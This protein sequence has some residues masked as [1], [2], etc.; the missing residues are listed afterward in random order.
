[1]TIK[2]KLQ[3]I[4]TELKA[5]KNQ[6][7]DFGN[8]NYRS[9]ED[10]LEGV[11]PLL[12]KVKAALTISDEIVNIGSRY[13]IKATAAL[14]DLESNEVFEISAFAR[15]PE[16]RPKM[17]E[18]Q[19]TGSSSSYARKYALNGLFCIDDTRDPDA[20]NTGK[21]EEPKGNK[22]KQ[23]GSSTKGKEKDVLKE[24]NYKT[25]VETIRR[26]GV[27]PE[28]VC[29]RYKKDSLRKLT[30][31]EFADAMKLLNIMPDKRPPAPDP[32]TQPSYYPPEG[33]Q[34]EMN[35]R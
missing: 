4:Q 26:K 29:E 34:M 5:P 14:H 11:K 18:A 10:I 21:K 31:A 15:E 23:Q 27:Y 33:Y 19:V 30:D 13:Y 6:Y 35:F 20:T 28:S 9:C 8:Y 12:V 16:S 7:N 22:G 25:L 1:M 24:S 32:R 2:E 3:M 17:D